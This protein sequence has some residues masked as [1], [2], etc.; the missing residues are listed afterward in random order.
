MFKKEKDILTFCT[1]CFIQIIGQKQRKN[2]LKVLI[3]HSFVSAS[4]I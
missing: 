4:P 2:D 1:G 3:G